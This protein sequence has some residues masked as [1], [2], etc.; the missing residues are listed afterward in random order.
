MRILAGSLHV[1]GTMGVGESTVCQELYMQLQNA[2][3]LDGD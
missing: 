1:N 2:V 3:W